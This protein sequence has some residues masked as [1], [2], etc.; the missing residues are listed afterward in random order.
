M[1]KLRVQEIAHSNGTTAMTV[2]ASGN[3]SRSVIPAWFYNPSGTQTFTNT[4]TMAPIT[5]WAV[6]NGLGDLRPRTFQQGGITLTD[7]TYVTVPVT[8]LYYIEFTARISSL[9][10]G[11]YA[12]TA[13]SINNETEQNTLVRHGGGELEDIYSGYL[14]LSASGI[15][16]LTANDNIR[17]LLSNE[18][19][20]SWS[21]VTVND[22]HFSGYFIG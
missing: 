7:S 3:V 15:Y 13:I 6:D 14:S 20:T 1:S 22:C 12:R 21:G 5:V 2:D 18:S 19:D 8:G 4:T 9:T 16:N 17:C 11:V 10:D